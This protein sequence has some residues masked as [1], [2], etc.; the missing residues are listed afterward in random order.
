M[1]DLLDWVEQKSSENLAFRSAMNEAL[2]KDANNFLTI[3]ITAMGATSAFAVNHYSSQRTDELFV[4][5]V[6]TSFWLF[7]L[8]AILVIKCIMTRLHLPPGNEPASLYQKN[9]SLEA[10]REAELK[11]TQFVIN[12]I[13]EE[14]EAYST[15]LDR[16][17]LLTLFSPF[18][19]LIS[20]W[21]RLPALCV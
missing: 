11:N 4:G 6:A 8:A 17:R 14:C 2:N 1:S 3:L 13:T 18:V 16:V 15:W 9:H 12:K 10:I 20:S 5:A 7:L 19:F 21:V